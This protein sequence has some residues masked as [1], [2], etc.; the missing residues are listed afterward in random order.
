MDDFLLGVVFR[1]YYFRWVMAGSCI[2]WTNIQRNCSSSLY[3][4]VVGLLAG[5]CCTGE[6]RHGNRAASSKSGAADV[7]EALGANISLTP[8][9][10]I[11]LLNRVGLCFFFAQYYHRSMFFLYYF[12]R[13]PLLLNAEL[14]QS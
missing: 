12:H 13:Y 11:A 4:D 8:D 1:L 7:L 2:V 5:V 6:L 3:L 10:C 9:A 14:V